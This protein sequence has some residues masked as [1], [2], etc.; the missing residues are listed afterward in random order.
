MP[1][2]A[3]ERCVLAMHICEAWAS[4]SNG[5]VV[6]MLACQ[7]DIIGQHRADEERPEHYVRRAYLALAR[8][9][10]PDKHGT[11]RDND[12]DIFTRAAMVLSAAKDDLANYEASPEGQWRRRRRRHAADN[13]TTTTTYDTAYDMYMD[14][15]QSGSLY[16]PFQWPPQRRETKCNIIRVDE[17]CS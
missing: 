7:H 12:D 8:E 17:C 10:H 14:R 2:D 3:R 5:V 6:M 15:V 16:D 9:V 11:S 13:T 4:T 1:L